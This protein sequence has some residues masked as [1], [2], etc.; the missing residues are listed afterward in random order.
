MIWLEIL[1]LAVV[2]GIGEFLPISS[3]GHVVVGQ[4]LFDQ[5]CRVS[6]PL[7]EQQKLRINIVL[8]VGTLLAILVFYRQRIRQLLGRD[9]RVLL[10]LVVG[11]L[12]A[13][14]AGLV[15]KRQFEHLL[16]DPLLAGFMFPV[17]GLML[18]WTARLQTGKTTCPDL[19]YGE[20]LLIGVFQAF[21]ILPGIS[22]SGAT[23]VAG[24]ACGL[25]R[26]EAAAFSFL[27][28]IPAIG[29]AGLLETIE[30]L[31]QPANA[32]PLAALAVGALVSFAV[33][34][35][36]LWWLVRWLRQGGLHYFAWWVIPLGLA[37][38][39]WQLL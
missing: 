7:S 27:L 20:A 15:L 2:Q 10:L 21:A 22:R 24:L 19:G 4:A 38:I 1:I 17:T 26:D 6:Q 8:H 28:A 16:T 5:F 14:I 32:T 9:W 23:I 31:S 13:A 25:R 18:L 30:L 39:A 34:L 33:G 29:G 36:S 3:S 11:S 12:P 35:A 37:V